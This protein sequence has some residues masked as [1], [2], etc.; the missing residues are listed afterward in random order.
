MTDTVNKK[1]LIKQGW[2]RVLLFFILYFLVNLFIA[3]PVVLVIAFIRP[4]A[5]TS[6][7]DLMSGEYLWVT[8]LVTAIAA[9]ITVFIF[10]KGVDRKSL[11]SLGFETSG[12]FAE[13]AS[14]FFL[15]LVILGIGSIVLYFS[16]HLQWTDIAFDPNHLFIAFG[17]ILMLVLTEEMVFR[18]YILSNLMESFNKWVALIISALLFALVHSLGPNVNLL[19]VAGLL[20]A[21]VLLGINYIYTKNLWYAIV[22]H[23]CWTFTQGPLLGYKMSG[24]NL[25]SLLQLETKGDDMITGGEFGFE[26]SAINILLLLVAISIL[27]FIYEKKYSTTEAIKA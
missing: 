17:M 3:V 15:A 25:P 12:Y 22:F 19:S 23:L 18:G 6:L 9:F 24:L 10:R 2:L 11:A 27:Y 5:G 7:T 1:P 20:L 8:L 21:G 16:G 26:A 13:G 14:G 4:S